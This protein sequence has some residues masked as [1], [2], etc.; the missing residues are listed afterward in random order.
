VIGHEEYRRVTHREQHFRR[1]FAE[2][3]RSRSFLFLGSGLA[4][5]YF[6]DLFGEIIDYYG[7]SPHPH[8]AFAADDDRLD[9]DFL[10]VRYGIQVHRYGRY[11]SLPRLRDRLAERINGWPGSGETWSFPLA[12]SKPATPRLLRITTDL[13]EASETATV[14]SGSYDEDRNLYFSEQIAALGE[15]LLESKPAVEDA[16]VARSDLTPVA[17]GIGWVFDEQADPPWRRDIAKIRRA[18][19][20]ALRWATQTLG[21]REIRFQLLSAG[22]SRH[23]PARFSLLSMLAGVRE[24][25]RDDSRGEPLTVVIHVLDA[26]LQREL[27]AGSVPV[28]EALA[29][30]LI[31]FSVIIDETG[32]SGAALG[33]P[34]NIIARDG[35][36]LQDVLG[37]VGFL[38]DDM[39]EWTV[40]VEPSARPRE[41]AKSAEMVANPTLSAL[42]VTFGSAIRIRRARGS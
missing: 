5:P 14:L 18:T 33:L 2:V 27:R 7:A 1:A 37:H 19:K 36:G 9:E 11:E 8:F 17:A 12:G 3:F 13:I 22:Q 4:E 24:W 32:V 20:D 26:P 6:L 34:V 21:R 16:F 25:L 30:D 40:S 42:A 15:P 39:S 10:R 31:P 28:A 23:F 41:A 29:S 38:P 35:A